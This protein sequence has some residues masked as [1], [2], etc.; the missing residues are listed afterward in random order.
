MVRLARKSSVILVLALCVGAPTVLAANTAKNS[1]ESSSGGVVSYRVVFTG[2]GTFTS[3]DTKAVPGSGPCAN[4]TDKVV[5]DSA[6]SWNTAY[7]ILVS[8]NAVGQTRTA[9]GTLST[10]TKP[11]TWKQTSTVSPSSCM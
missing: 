9:E 4:A 2:S 1:G 3:T 10:T 8:H 7:A 6:F 11:G 5:E